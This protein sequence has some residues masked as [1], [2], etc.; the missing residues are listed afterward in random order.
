MVLRVTRSTA[1]DIESFRLEVDAD[2]AEVLA[3]EPLGPGGGPGTG[4]G[5]C[6]AQGL[7][8]PAVSSGQP[9]S[10]LAADIQQAALDCDYDRLAQLASPTI[11]YSFGGS[12]DFAGHLRDAEAGGD[13]PMR[14][15]ALL[16]GAA[17][18]ER[19][20]PAQVVWPAFFACEATCG[21]D[22]AELRRLG[23]SDDDIAQFRDFGGYAGYRAGFAAGGSGSYTWTFFVAGD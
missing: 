20:D 14:K 9:W 3:S 1:G 19:A 23:Y 12:G 22:E 10:A 21:M 8:A 4:S 6:S 2:T 5:T 18:G 13:D 16:L 7:A 11:S 15:L 17:P